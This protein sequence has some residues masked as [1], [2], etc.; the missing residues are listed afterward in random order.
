MDEKYLEQT[1]NAIEE[2]DEAEDDD[3]EEELIQFQRQV[4]R[5]MELNVS[6]DELE[7]S[8]FDDDD[9]IGDQETLFCKS[10]ESEEED[11][12]EQN[13]EEEI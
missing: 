3:E 9:E 1:K 11:F 6:N 10:Y 2:D 13:D 7:Q 12:E 4:N 5:Q 8:M